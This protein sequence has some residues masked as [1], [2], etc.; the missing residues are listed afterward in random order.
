[1]TCFYCFV[2][3]EIL[4]FRSKSF[5]ANLRQ[6]TFYNLNLR[7][8][9]SNYRA[10]KK[11]FLQDFTL[12]YPILPKFIKNYHILRKTFSNSDPCNYVSSFLI[13]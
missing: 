8:L 13:L 5:C 9:T 4:N 12:N 1:M 6:F 3:S 7:I 10:G 2:I 11:H